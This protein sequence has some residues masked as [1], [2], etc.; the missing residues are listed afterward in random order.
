MG[1]Y[2]LDEVASVFSKRKL[3]QR[4]LAKHC[5]HKETL[6]TWLSFVMVRILFGVLSWFRFYDDNCI[7]YT[8][9]RSSECN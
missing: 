3:S 2:I 5:S 8:V 9:Y 1:T 6:A 7:P 4:V